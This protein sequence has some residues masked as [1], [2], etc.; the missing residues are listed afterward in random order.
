MK[1]VVIIGDNGGGL[2]YYKAKPFNIHMLDSEFIKSYREID[3]EKLNDMLNSEIKSRPYLN[4]VK[5]YKVYVHVN[6]IKY[7]NV[8]PI[9]HNT[10][11]DFNI[12]NTKEIYKH[13]PKHIFINYDFISGKELPYSQAIEC[14]NEFETNCLTF[15]NFDNLS[16]YNDIIVRKQNG[17]YI[18]AIELLNNEYKYCEKQ[19]RISHNIC[20]MLLANSFE[21]RKGVI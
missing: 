15:F 4:D 1:Y 21:F 13:K 20:K 8:I 3:N 5:L 11:F 9:G 14:K 10:V 2:T 17:D 12:V 16:E 7:N 6:N 19:I 18:C